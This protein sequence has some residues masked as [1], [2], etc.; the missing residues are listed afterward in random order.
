MRLKVFIFTL[1]LGSNISAAL[2][3]PVDTWFVFR[4]GAKTTTEVW[5]GEKPEAGK[6]VPGDAVIVPIKEKTD[7]RDVQLSPEGKLIPLE[8]TDLPLPEPTYVELRSAAYEHEMPLGDQLD[9]LYKGLTLVLP[10]VL[11]KEEP[12]PEVVEM[13]TPNPSA[14]KGTPAWWF[15]KIAE[16]KA[17]YPKRKDG[18]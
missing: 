8:K 11:G 10:I 17:K 12:T 15:S 6:S 14:E 13:L 18:E 9:A 1:V 4:D 3:A 2:A 16:I 7:P 5:Q